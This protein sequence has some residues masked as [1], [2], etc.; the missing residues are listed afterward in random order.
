MG[1]ESGLSPGL[2]PDYSEAF[3]PSRFPDLRR[4]G[5]FEVFPTLTTKHY[6]L[7]TLLTNLPSATWKDSVLL[8]IVLYFHIIR[9]LFGFGGLLNIE[10]V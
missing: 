9:K 1:Y 6:P 10:H 5:A 4:Q 2:L 8:N 3:P 7:T